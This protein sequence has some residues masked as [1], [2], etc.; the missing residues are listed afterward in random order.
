M[1]TSPPAWFRGAIVDGISLLMTLRLDGSPAADTIVATGAAWIRSLWRRRWWHQ[2]RDLPRI[3]AAF[4]SIAA[5][6]T[7][8]PAPAHL[9]HALPPVDHQHPIAIRA[10][11][12]YLKTEAKSDPYLIAHNHQLIAEL[13]SQLQALGTQASRLPCKQSPAGHH[14]NPT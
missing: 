2:E 3:V 14:P 8:W 4:D 13:Q 10:R 9:I 5:S 12:A 7:S 11:I 1:T 6:F